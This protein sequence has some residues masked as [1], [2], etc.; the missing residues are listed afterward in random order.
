[1]LL[2]PSNAYSYPANQVRSLCLTARSHA[3][4]ARDIARSAP[5]AG[6]LVGFGVWLLWKMCFAGINR[7]GEVA[8]LPPSP[9]VRI[10][11]KRCSPPNR[12]LDFIADFVSLCD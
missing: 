7:G 11:C 2:H 5:R 4:R 9:T 12:P 6:D 8:S 3:R 10:K 1:L